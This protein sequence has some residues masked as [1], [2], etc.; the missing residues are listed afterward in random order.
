M[1]KKTLKDLDVKGKKVFCRVDFNVPMKDGEVTDDT[2]IKAALPTIKHLSDNG[3]KVILASHLGRPKGQAV[4]ELRL[5]PVA[6]RLSELSGKEVVKTDAVYGE[7]VNEAIANLHDGDLLLIENVRFESGEEKNDP[8]LVQ[9]FAS[10]ADLYVNDAFGAA[11]RAHAST[12]GIAEKLPSAAGFLM[13]KEISVLSKALENPE[14]PFT[15]IIGGAKVK[16][17][18]DVIDN[19]LDKV[20]NLI[21][22]GGLAYTFIKAQGHEIGK[23][24]LEEDKI[25]L[26]K[27]FMQKAKEKGVNFVLPEDVVI[28]DDFSEEANTKEV[29]IEEIPADWEALDIGPK[30][31]EK[32]SKIVSE[33]KLVIWNGPMGVFEL[34]VFANGTKAVAEA[35]ATTEG[36]T[37]IG[38]GDSAAA[39]EKFGLADKMD[40]VSTGG[41]ASLEFMEGKVLPGVAA[42]DEK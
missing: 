22:G 1:N 39:V 11:H 26:A 18:I 32:Y 21:V 13:E 19:L 6:K 41:G 36:Y 23:S 29:S 35:L 38:G 7:E 2:R 40:H 25:D 5:D 9:S 31:R 20:D 14:R 34:N 42:L 8:A 30:T 24:L 27:E 16:D 37:V 28:A 10:M 15:A 33:S 12:T 4:E 3:A 17:K